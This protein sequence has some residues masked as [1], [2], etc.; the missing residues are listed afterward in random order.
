[1]LCQKWQLRNE[2]IGMMI[3]FADSSFYFYDIELS[4]LF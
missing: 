4:L 3:S 2:E 1:M